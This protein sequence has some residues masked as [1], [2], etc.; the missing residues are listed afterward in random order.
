[1]VKHL[2]IKNR[3]TLYRDEKPGEGLLWECRWHPGG[4]SVDSRSSASGN[5]KRARHQSVRAQRSCRGRGR[6]GYCVQLL[7][8]DTLPPV[9]ACGYTAVSVRCACL[10][11]RLSWWGQEWSPGATFAKQ[12]SRWEYGVRTRG[13]MFLQVPGAWVLWH[14]SWGAVGPLVPI[15]KTKGTSPE[16][17]WSRLHLPMQGTWVRSLFG[18]LRFHMLQGN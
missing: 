7:S 4:L 15:K 17:Q 18:D 14:I 3:V 16:V 13:I 1:M 11:A 9:H 6:G 8:L 10:W 5:S 12:W 2:Q